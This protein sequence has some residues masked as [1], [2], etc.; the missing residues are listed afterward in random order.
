MPLMGAVTMPAGVVALQLMPSELD[1][2]ALW[3]IGL[4]LDWIL[5]VAYWVSHLE[6]AVIF[7]KAPTLVVLR[8][9]TFSGLFL[10]LWIGSF[11]AVGVLLLWWRLC[12]G[13]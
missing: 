13:G 4:G 1:G 10:A 2:V 6:N 11:C 5:T 9:M 3:V 12:F 7:V 8:L